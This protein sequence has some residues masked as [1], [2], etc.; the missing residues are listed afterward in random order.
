[1]HGK[2]FFYLTTHSTTCG[3]FDGIDVFDG[4]VVGLVEVALGV[5]DEAVDGLEKLLNRLFAQFVIFVLRHK[6]RNTCV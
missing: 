3:T 4:Q 6:P 1:M 5:G 2:L